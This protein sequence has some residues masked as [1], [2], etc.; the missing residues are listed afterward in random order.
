MIIAAIG[1]SALGV[2]T[3]LPFLMSGVLLIFSG[4][5]AAFK[6]SGA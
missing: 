2:A 6:N 3:G 4:L 5:M 1:I